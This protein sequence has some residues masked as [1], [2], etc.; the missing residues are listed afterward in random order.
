VF[1]SRCHI[2][3]AE[4][5]TPSLLS[6]AHLSAGQAGC[7]Y[8]IVL[9]NNINTLF[10]FKLHIA[11]CEFANQRISLHPDRWAHTVSELNNPMLPI[12]R[13]TQP[14]CLP[15]QGMP[16]FSVLLG[17]WHRLWSACCLLLGRLSS[18]HGRLHWTCSSTTSHC[19]NVGIEQ[20]SCT[21]KSCAAHLVPRYDMALVAQTLL[22]QQS[23]FS[24]AGDWLLQRC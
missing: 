4:Q 2:S 7:Q 12:I 15:D 3:A 8:N 19:S 14:G 22:L 9:H 17:S 21:H 6:S 13:G 20:A 18:H 16:V 11:V 10:L 1:D 24:L 23:Y 5:Q